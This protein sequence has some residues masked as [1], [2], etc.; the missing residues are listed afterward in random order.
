[1]ATLTFVLPV[2]SVAL[3]ATAGATDGSNP[4]WNLVINDSGGTDQLTIVA[5]TSS[6]D[7]L[8]AFAKQIEDAVS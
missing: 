5:L 4:Q 7:D 2:A 3:S 6:K 8:R 1:M